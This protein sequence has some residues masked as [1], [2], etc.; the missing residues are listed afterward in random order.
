MNSKLSTPKKSEFGENCFLRDL[1]R[2]YM[3]TK[4]IN[5]YLHNR[6]GFESAEVISHRALSIPLIII[7]VEQL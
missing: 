2:L 4:S 1:G 5:K 6:F 7:F 3:Y